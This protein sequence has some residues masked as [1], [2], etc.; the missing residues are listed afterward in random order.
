MIHTDE[1][2]LLLLGLGLSVLQGPTRFIAAIKWQQQQNCCLQQMQSS[3][4]CAVLYILTPRRKALC[5]FPC[6]VF[7]IFPP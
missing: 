3:V 4:T 5:S 2:V 6:P 7:D 1:D